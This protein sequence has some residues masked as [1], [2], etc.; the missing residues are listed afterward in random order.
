[1]VPLLKTAVLLSVLFVLP[2]CPSTESQLVSSARDS[3]PIA[4]IAASATA[5]CSFGAFVQ[6]TDPAGLHVRSKPDP[7]SAVLGTLPP[8]ITSRELDG[9]KVRVE[10]QVLE[11]ENG[12][13]RIA[14]AQD[15]SVLTGQPERT[16][17]KGQGW[18]SGR[19]LTVKSQARAAYAQPNIKS[20]VAFSFRDGSSFDNDQMIQAGHLIDCQGGWV[21]VEF[22]D[23]N[24]QNDIRKE[25]LVAATARSA[26][27]DHHFRAWVNQICGIQETSCD[28]LAAASRESTSYRGRYL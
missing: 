18:V 3:L 9:L 12:W 16:M 8:V 4:T 17:F 14:Q 24:L 6:E 21:L 25:L 28:G 7:W 10:V 13:F 27:P 15:N 5:E 26:L 1:M 2:S 22:N 23:Q 20:P 19:K 11:S